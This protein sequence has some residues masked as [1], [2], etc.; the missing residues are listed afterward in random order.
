MVLFLKCNNSRHTG[1]PCVKTC[2]M[3]KYSTT[4]ILIS[5]WPPTSCQ[6]EMTVGHVTELDWNET[7]G[8]RWKA[9]HPIFNPLSHQLLAV[10]AF[11]CQLFGFFYSNIDFA[12]SPTFLQ[13]Y[14]LNSLYFLWCKNAMSSYSISITFVKCHVKRQYINILCYTK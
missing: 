9:S 13:H 6:G 8:Q 14:S 3:G 4:R 5:H 10:V 7:G 2:P 11:K 12:N 1:T